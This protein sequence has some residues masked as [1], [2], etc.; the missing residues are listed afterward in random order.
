MFKH[1]CVGFLLLASA[2]GAG[3]A[4]APIIR[5]E[6][7]LPTTRF[8]F[9]EP[10]SKVYLADP[11]LRDIMPAALNGGEKLLRGSR[12]DD[13]AIAMRLRVYLASAAILQGRTRDALKLIAEARN[14]APKA[15]T[16]AIGFLG[17]E[18]A[19]AMING[20]CD[21]AERVVR[22]RLAGVDPDLVHDEVVARYGLTQSVSPG[23]H[24]A[25]LVIGFDGEAEAQKSLGLL[26]T[27]AV[28]NIRME[29]SILPRCRDQISAP[30]R[31]WLDDP[32]NQPK[33]IWT[34][35]APS[36]AA[37]AG[38]KPVTVAIW[39][40]GYDISVFPGQLAY[41]P[42]EPLDGTDND[43][44][45]V[46]DDAWGPTYD[47]YLRPTPLINQPLS[48][49]LA[50]RLPLQLMLM[51]GEL[52][53][54]YGDD[55]PEARLFAQRSREATPAEQIGDART[56]EETRSRSHATWVASIVA[57]DAPFVKLYNFQSVPFGDDPEPVAL[58]E[59]GIARWE[60]TLPAAAK[61]MRDAGVRIVNMSW[62][63][64]ADELA[65]KLLARG[66]E[67][68][69]KRARARGAAIQKRIV[70]LLARTMRSCPNILFVAA[71]G[72]SDQSDDILAAAPSNMR[73]PNLLVVGAVGATGRPTTFTTFGK[74][75]RLYA[76]GEGNR[77][78]GLG[79]MQMRASGTSFAAPEAARVAAQML[80][81]APNL[82]PRQLIE[83]LI[84]TA[85]VG[86]GAV[87]LVHGAS[88][89]NWAIERQ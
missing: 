30:M 29:A 36:T 37:L 48:E 3:F 63:S 18:A 9:E 19:A 61:R 16:K 10:P 51:K 44:N 47:P 26:Q 2:H 54:G 8:P 20:G 40:A 55:T 88:A 27:L 60:A 12:I 46:V 45:G 86:D 80:A 11:F 78:T 74:N 81:I 35:R 34:E 42:A 69:P 15:Q 71:A 49:V 38:A 43:G 58:D 62:G 66:L 39:E 32:R 68:D 83:G 76:L 53:L 24:A 25:S 85:T 6:A 84:S 79:G 5:S 57:H 22:Q 59:D 56:Y 1:A 75:V 13:P 87:T 82:T 33:S 7:D 41:D 89:V 21:A 50:R 64:D 4:Q 31:A 17:H 14:A 65:G 77:V 52:D 73:E 67:T 28:V 23:Y 72:N 70:T